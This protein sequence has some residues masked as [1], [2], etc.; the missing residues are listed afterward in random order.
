MHA[1]VCVYINVHACVRVINVLAC[2][3][4]HVCVCVYMHVHACVRVYM[5]EHACVRAGI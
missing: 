3:C 1:C 4:M 2:V 5:N